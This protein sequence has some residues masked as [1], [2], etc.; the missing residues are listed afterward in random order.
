[1]DFS[2]L[3]RL[4]RTDTPPNEPAPTPPPG[5][6]TRRRG[7]SSPYDRYLDEPPPGSS[8]VEIWMSIGFGL[9]FIFLGF[10]YGKYLFNVGESVSGRITGTGVVVERRD[11][12]GRAG[13]GSRRNWKSR[14]KTE[15]QQR[16]QGRRLAILS[17]SSLFLFGV[18]MCWTGWSAA[19]RGCAAVSAGA[20]GGRGWSGICVTVAAVAYCLYVVVAHW[21]ADVMARSTF[22][23]VILGGLMLSM[24]FALL[25]AVPSAAPLRRAAAPAAPAAAPRGR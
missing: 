23:C 13:G 21:R 18:A 22:V 11:S 12:E 17:E 25:R 10:N 1:M 4:S 9:L 3:P 20:A 24:Q 19:W 14:Y 6:R 7:T 2:K 15:Y 5:R 16:I 8:G